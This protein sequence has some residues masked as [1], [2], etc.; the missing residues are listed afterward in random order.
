[1]HAGP[2]YPPSIV[3][4]LYE[5]HDRLA[6]Q[7]WTPSVQRSDFVC[8]LAAPMVIAH[9]VRREGAAPK[10]RQRLTPQELSTLERLVEDELEPRLVA[11]ASDCGAVIE[12]VATIVRD[13]GRGT[14]L[15]SYS[16]RT[17]TWV[18][19]TWLEH[20]R[21][22]P[23]DVALFAR[24]LVDEAPGPA[25]TKGEFAAR[26]AA[27][28]D[29]AWSREGAANLRTHPP[30]EVRLG[31]NTRPPLVGGSTTGRRDWS[32]GTGRPV[33]ERYRLRFKLS[34]RS[35]SPQCSSPACQHRALATTDDPALTEVLR[36]C[37]P[38]GLASA[39][40]P[41][42]IRSLL[43]GIERL[44]RAAGG[45]T[46]WEKW[47]TPCREIDVRGPVDH[48][49]ADATASAF[50]AWAVGPVGEPMVDTYGFDTLI[51]P[52][53][54]VVTRKAWMELLGYERA[55]AQGMR[56]CGIPKVVRTA[57]YLH[58][59]AAVRD[60][61][62]GDIGDADNLPPDFPGGIDAHA[63][64]FLE[65][66]QRTLQLLGTKPAVARKMVDGDLSWRS[67]YEALI[68]SDPSRALTC[69]D[70]FDALHDC[71]EGMH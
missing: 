56:R 6:A 41:Q 70:A 25:L 55:F 44:S 37:A 21:P 10:A 33:F 67:D 47:V 11:A 15:R 40:H 54:T 57:L 26:Y 35:S 22:G 50:S 36:A 59:P 61:I 12:A 7:G 48:E 46:T 64:A 39:G 52:L 4:W 53:A 68:A 13:Q 71:L 19:T 58:S 62:N 17:A 20:G 8:Q 51:G 14:S 65:R 24:R 5:R 27:H 45:W 28:Y 3:G 66:R 42:I 60:W 29:A 38:Y 63:H 18:R 1:M 32:Q 49:L 43:D 2:K 9:W 69:E 30:A 23:D 16:E 31:P 34:A